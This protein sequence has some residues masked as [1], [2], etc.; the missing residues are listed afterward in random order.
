MPKAPWLHA[1]TREG[2]SMASK[3]G[4]EQHLLLV[5]L[6]LPLYRGQ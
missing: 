6:V 1:T 3:A 5:G 2:V 4:A